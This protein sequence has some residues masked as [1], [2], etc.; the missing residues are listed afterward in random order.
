MIFIS[1]LYTYLVVLM[2][3]TFLFSLEKFP[4]KY[5][6][7]FMQKKCVL[8]HLRRIIG[9]FWILRH[10][11][12]NSIDP[13]VI[14]IDKF[15]FLVLSYLNGTNLYKSYC[16]LLLGLLFRLWKTAEA[17]TQCLSHFQVRFSFAVC[18]TTIRRVFSAWKM[19]YTFVNLS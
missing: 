8:R 11:P 17:R 4:I 19:S 9:W 13:F 15:N 3:D 16:W 2:V 14:W 6:Y 12:S 10:W 7:W 18:P 5:V 1:Y